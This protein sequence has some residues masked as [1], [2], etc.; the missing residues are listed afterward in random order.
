MHRIRESG[1]QQ[2][3]YRERGFKA[4]TQMLQHVNAVGTE[5]AQEADDQL[6]EICDWVRQR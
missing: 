5:L 2:Q 3:Q 4:D 1:R 6:A